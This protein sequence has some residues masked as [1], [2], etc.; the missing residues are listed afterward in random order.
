MALALLAGGASCARPAPHPGAE[1]TA[2]APPPGAP[3]GRDGHGGGSAGGARDGGRG[4]DAPARGAVALGAPAAPDGGQPAPRWVGALPAAESE[5]CR[6]HL[7]ALDD[8]TC[9]VV[10]DAESTE[11]LVHL[12]GIVPPAGASAVQANLQRVVSSAALRAGVTAVLPRGVQGLAPRGHDGW[13]GWPTSARAYD[14][15]GAA[16]VERLVEVRARLERLRGSPFR[17]AYVV[18]SS[19][20]AYFVALLAWRGALAADG[21]GA[22]SGGGVV[23]GAAASGARAPFYL[24]YGDRDSVGASVRALGAAL[25]REGFPIELAAHPTGHGVREAYLDEAL[26]F[27]RSKAR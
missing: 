16:L 27:F 1:P 15:H 22:L 6:P 19:S 21:W 2:G 7:R 24:G 17:R 4:R 14:R 8:E 26:R 3:R 12:H 18:G 5:W 23:S 9:V 11:L 10:P 20:G 13:W 25:G